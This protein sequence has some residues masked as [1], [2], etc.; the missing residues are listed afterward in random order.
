MRINLISLLTFSSGTPLHFVVITDKNSLENVDKTL[1]GIIKQYVTE[2]ILLTKWRRI[3][4]VPKIKYSYV[5]CENIVKIDPV[6]FKAMKS[7][8]VQ[9][10]G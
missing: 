5:D 6:F 7:N 8:S 2:G 9:G 4:S 3:K 10:R 1:K